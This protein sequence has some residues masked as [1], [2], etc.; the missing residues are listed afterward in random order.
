MHQKVVVY[1]TIV[2]ELQ[3]RGITPVYISVSN[4]EKPYYATN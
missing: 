2:A 3:A 1:E 4:K